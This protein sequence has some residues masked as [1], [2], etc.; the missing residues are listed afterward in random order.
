MQKTNQFYNFNMNDMNVEAS[1]QN[2]YVPEK[3]IRDVAHS[4]R[5]IWDTSYQANQDWTRIDSRRFVNQVR[6]KKIYNFS[7]L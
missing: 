2:Y 5:N 3:R 6:I 1:P 7:V 4:N